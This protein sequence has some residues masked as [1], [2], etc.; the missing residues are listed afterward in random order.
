MDRDTILNILTYGIPV[1]MAVIG[2]I[3]AAK[4]ITE[5]PRGTPNYAR[6]FWIAVFVVMGLA[7]V[8]L[9]GYQSARATAKDQAK[10]QEHQRELQKSEARENYLSGQVASMSQVLGQIYSNSNPSKTAAAVRA[11][12]PPVQAYDARPRLRS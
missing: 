11:A 5:V 7:S 12:F 8:A 1:V 6:R 4:P 2:G 3:L 10:D 9:M